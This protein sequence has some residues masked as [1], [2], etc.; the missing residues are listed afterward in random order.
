MTPNKIL[1]VFA[2]IFSTFASAQVGIGT[3]NPQG[4]FNIDGAK[5]NATSGP[6]TAAQ[7]NDDFVVTA[8]GNVGLGTTSPTNRLHVNGASLFTPYATNTGT[9][10]G[11]D[12]IA[13]EIYGKTNGAPDTQV[14]GLKFKWYN[15]IGGIEMIRPASTIGLGIAF[16]IASTGNVTSEAMRITSAGNVGIGKSGPSEKLDVD[17]NIRFSGALMP[18]N[19]PG[20]AG[21]VLTSA[22][23]GA[24]PTWATAAGA[25]NIYNSDGTLTGNRTVTQG[26]NSLTFSGTGKVGI[27]ITSTTAKL[28]V[29]SEL[30]ST[31][32]VNAAATLLQLSRPS[33]SAV[34][35]GSIARFN[36]G[37]YEASPSPNN[38]AKSRLDLAMTDTNGSIF[39]NVMTWQANGNVGIGT[40]APSGGLT[41][42]GNSV[43]GLAGSINGISSL[44]KEIVFGRGGGTKGVAAI[45]A[46]DQ[47]GFGGGLAFFTKAPGTDNFPSSAIQTMSLD[48]FG[49]VGIGTTAPTEKLEVA[50]KTKTTNFQ[51]T[52]GAA[53]GAVLVTD[54]QGNATWDNTFRQS[55]SVVMASGSSNTFTT[56]ISSGFITI[57]SGN[58]CGRPMIALF[59]FNESTM[60]QINSVARNAIG[61]ATSLNADNTSWG[62]VFSGVTGCGDGGSG[63]Q[64]DFT[65]SK[66]GNIIT[67]SGYTYTVNKNYNIIVTN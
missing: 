65:I 46:V 60:I 51:M 50:G 20:T 54:A 47:G 36:M 57:T 39:T 9:N 33:T 19:L 55:G 17:G 13:F 4:I 29:G 44:T 32:N 49:N 53:N 3:Q 58:A 48:W 15:S 63:P 61:V 64:F 31:D 7:Q 67:L 41:L 43:L 22:G 2:L 5:N 24:V 35:W 18:N 23:A 1:L 45:A 25:T 52:N 56:T 38:F 30:V 42:F 40:T 37:S 16:N 10:A 34:K 59:A 28:E 66:S 12:Q 26:A 6:P 21:Q 62:V 11:G 27:G 8:A 14:G